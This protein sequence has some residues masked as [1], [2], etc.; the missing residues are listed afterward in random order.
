M[1]L[2]LIPAAGKTVL[3][4]NSKNITVSN[5]LL[6]TKQNIRFFETFVSE[7]VYLFFR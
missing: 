6:P 3:Q 7:N 1:R 4:V 5:K 2:N